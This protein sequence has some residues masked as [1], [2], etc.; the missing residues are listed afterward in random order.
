MVL[1]PVRT[2]APF[3]VPRNRRRYVLAPVAFTL[4]LAACE[5]PT[6]GWVDAA[7]VATKL[8]SPLVSPPYLATDSTLD[9]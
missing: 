2:L 3:R 9:A 7:A 6:V 5:K 8:P 1:P 4:L